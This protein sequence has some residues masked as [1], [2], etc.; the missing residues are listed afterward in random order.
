M[1]IAVV[2]TPWSVTGTALTSLSVT[3]AGSGN[4]L[5][6]AF[7]CNTG[8]GVVASS[9]SGGGVPA[10]GSGAWARIG[11]PYTDTAYSAGWETWLGTTATPGA[12]T[13]AVTWSGSVVGANVSFVAG[14]FASGWG[15]QTLWSGDLSAGRS[16]ASSTTVACPTLAPGTTNPE[17]YFGYL[18][19]DSAGTAGAT[20]GYTYSMNQ[21]SGSMC[22]NGAITASTSP[23]WTQ[24]PTGASAGIAALIKATP[25]PIAAQPYTARRRAANF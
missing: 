19:H 10:A 9:V 8:T 22:W 4:A 23:T 13:I 21:A 7:Y 5:I 11:S 2:G 6:F 20:A 24:S 17:L 12:T 15:A 1:P 14:E 3:P 16:N 25:L 18:Y